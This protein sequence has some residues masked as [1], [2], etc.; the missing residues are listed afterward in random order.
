MNKQPMFPWNSGCYRQGVDNRRGGSAERIGIFGLVQKQA[1]PK[2]R[3]SAHRLHLRQ[4]ETDSQRSLDLP[5]LEPISGERRLRNL[6]RMQRSAGDS[7]RTVRRDRF[8]STTVN[9]SVRCRGF[10]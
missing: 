4:A 5:V 8:P 7:G 6:H 10:P 1:G 3:Q 9:L 2:T